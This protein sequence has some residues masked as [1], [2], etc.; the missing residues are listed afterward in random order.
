[1]VTIA[2]HGQNPRLHC[3][4]LYFSY[5]NK[6]RKPTQDTLSGVD[7]SVQPS[8]CLGLIGPNGAGKSTLLKLAAGLLKPQTG[9]I[10]FEGQNLSAFKPRELGKRIAYVPQAFTLP[11]LYQVSDIVLQGRHPHMKG[12]A[13]ES[14]HDLEIARK[15]MEQTDVWH[16]RDRPFDALSGGERQRVVI[17]SALAQQPKLLILDEPTSSLDL[18]FQSTTVKLVRDLVE[19]ENMSVLV[20]LHD[21]NLAGA[22]CDRL[23][24]LVRGKLRGHGTPQDVLDRKL[25]ENAYETELF[26]ETGPQGIYVLPVL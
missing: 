13:F 14:Q 22:M 25:L 26:V 1:M 16:L 10:T 5:I 21:L 15:V 20:A 18:R 11:F 17:A 12:A 3:E 2:D 19:S 8:Q 24:L 9:S 4:N 23:A 7:L 6:G